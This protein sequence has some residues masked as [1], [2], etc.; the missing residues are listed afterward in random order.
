MFPTTAD[1]FDQLLLPQPLYHQLVEHACRTLPI[2]CC[3]LL[4]GVVHRRQG[5]VTQVLALANALASPVA[6]RTDP[7]DLLHAFRLLRRFELE[8][9]G[10]YHSH[11]TAPPQPSRRDLEQNTYGSAVAHLIVSLAGPK[12]TLSAWRLFPDNFQPLPCHLIAT[13]VRPTPAAVSPPPT[14]T[15]PTSLPYSEAVD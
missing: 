5:Y 1:P 3:G 12:P 8:L 4:A 10:F 6:Y 13:P 7:R 15:M 14:T 11:P 9:L 2:E